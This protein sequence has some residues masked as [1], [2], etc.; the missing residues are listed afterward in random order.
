[1]RHI[2]PVLANLAEVSLFAAGACLLILAA[3]ALL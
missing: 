1:M 3:V 2:Y